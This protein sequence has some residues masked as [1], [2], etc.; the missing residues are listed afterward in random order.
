MNLAQLLRAGRSD[1]VDSLVFSTPGLPSVTFHDD[2]RQ[3][4]K[5]AAMRVEIRLDTGHRS[6]VFIRMELTIDA[7]GRTQRELV[8]E[9][10][11]S[12][13][14]AQV[15]VELL[16]D[17]AWRECERKLRRAIAEARRGRKITP[18]LSEA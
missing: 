8:I 5:D 2:R 14:A 18:P 10:N 6:C 9:R 7:T 11:A 16:P 3:Q 15:P 4:L 13:V 12:G 17:G 1:A